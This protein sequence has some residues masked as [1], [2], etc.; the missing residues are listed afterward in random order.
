MHDPPPA[1]PE[2][3]F[4]KKII[5]AEPI[6][7]TFERSDTVFGRGSISLLSAAS[8]EEILNLH[9]AHKA[10]LIITDFDLPFMGAVK[11]CS[12]IRSDAGLKKVSIIVVCN[13]SDAS[14]AAC[15]ESGANAFIPKPAD[16]NVLF[17]KISELLVVPQRKDMRVLQRI[18]VKSVEGDATFFAQSLNISI[19]GMLLET[20]RAFKKGDRLTCAFNIAHSEIVVECMVMRTDRTASG[21]RRYGVKFM[22]YD[23]KSLIIIDQFVKAQAKR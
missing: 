3:K 5:I 7:R 20:D 2:G 19:S 17:A 9:G 11:L 8:S 12:L 6:I 22:N 21:R 10:D 15:Q 18:S 16:P 13:N 1:K 4:M 14:Q 23:T